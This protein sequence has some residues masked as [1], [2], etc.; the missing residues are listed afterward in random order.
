MS[1]AFN[2]FQEIAGLHS[3]NLGIGFNTIEKEKGVAWV[4]IRMRVDMI[5]Y[6]VWDEEVILETW[7][8][9]PKSID[10]KGFLY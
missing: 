8:Q 10:L 1:A 7:P 6:P 2:Y 5:R 4:L 3:S 9:L